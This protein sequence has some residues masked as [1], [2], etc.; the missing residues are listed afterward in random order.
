MTFPFDN[1]ESQIYIAF[2][3]PY[4]YT[5]HLEDLGK[6][7]REYLEDESIYFRKEILIKSIESRNVYLLTITANDWSNQTKEFETIFSEWLFPEH[8]ERPKK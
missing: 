8:K 6:L 3:Y 2:T 1:R 7:E 5:Q 4:T